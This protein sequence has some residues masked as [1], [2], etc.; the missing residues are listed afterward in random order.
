MRWCWF[1]PNRRKSVIELGDV[2]GSTSKLLKAAVSRPEKKFIV[3][4]DLGILH[5]MQ[6][7]G[8]RQ[9][10]H[11]RADGRRRKLQKLRVLPLMAM[12]LAG[13]HQ[14]RP[15]RRAQR[16][17]V[18]QKAGRSRQT[19]FCSVCSTSRQGSRRDVFNGM[20]PA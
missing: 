13:R 14:I 9:R 10:I 11:R 19:A 12:N 4:T 6:K 17:P 1:I 5:E 15:D 7:A 16:N 2:V 8:A 20:G 18:G 3:A